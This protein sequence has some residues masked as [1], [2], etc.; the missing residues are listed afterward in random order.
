MLYSAAVIPFRPAQTGA[1]NFVLGVLNGL[2][3]TLAETLIDPTLVLVAFVSRLTDSPILIGLVAPLRDGGWFLPQVWLSGYVQSLPHKL[4]L[5]RRTALLRAGAWAA[6][7][8]AVFVIRDPGWLLAAFFGTF[9]LYA[10]ASGAGGLAFMEV[11]GK[12]IPPNRRAVF[13]AWR[14]FL[15][16]LAALGAAGVVRGLLDQQLGL[17]FPENFGWLF[18]LGLPFA[19]AG[20][21]TFSAIAEPPDPVVQPRATVWS[22]VRRGWAILRGDAAYRRFLA[23]RACL[24]VAGAA[25]PF[26]AV[27][28][29]T[30]LGGSLAMVGA[31]L[32][33]YTVTSLAANVVFGRF[34]AR[35]GNRG[36][37]RAATLAGL[38]MSATVAALLVTAW[39]QPLAPA[40]AA[41][42]LLP[43]YALAGVRESGLGVSTQPLLLEI[44]PVEARSLYLGFTNSLLGLA[45]LST[46]LSGVVVATFGFAALLGVALVAN[47]LALWVAL[48]LR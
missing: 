14:L 34:A 38:L 16:G 31:Y 45:L 12:T 24:M 2:F 25:V 44:A 1:R 40:V 23:W 43:A 15:G 41:A 26:F 37:L 10:L 46:G 33:T 42:W 27:Y 48:R 8:A 9:G 11:V 29:Q 21:W 30:R 7:A 3:F 18:G 6:M 35:L 20:L 47:A 39:W 28:V 19:V 4:G 5:Y 17:E 22:Q 13:F 32:A 36:I